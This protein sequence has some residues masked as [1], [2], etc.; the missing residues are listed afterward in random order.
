MKKKKIRRMMD[1]MKRMEALRIVKMESMEERLD[2][3]E[4]LVYALE[5]SL[6]EFTRVPIVTVDPI[7]EDS[8][9]SLELGIDEYLKRKACQGKK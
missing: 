5:G 2:E 8:W 4:E 1:Q 3:L 6:F 9:E 7:Y